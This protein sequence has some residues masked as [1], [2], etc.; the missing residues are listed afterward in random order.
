MIEK[1]REKAY[2]LTPSA[3]CLLPL[4]LFETSGRLLEMIVR[5][6]KKDEQMKEEIT[7]DETEGKI[8]VDWQAAQI[9]IDK[10]KR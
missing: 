7:C 6:E 3:S 8:N 4:L 9:E 10:R 1:R 2:L 5:K